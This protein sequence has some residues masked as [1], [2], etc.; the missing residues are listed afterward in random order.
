MALFRI[1]LLQREAIKE[2]AVLIL[3]WECLEILVN[4]AKD[5]YKL[6]VNVENT[7]IWGLLEFNHKP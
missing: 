4:A 1:M 3:F 7:Q 5:F 2:T 6:T